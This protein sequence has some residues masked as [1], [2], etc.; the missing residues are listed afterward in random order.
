MVFVYRQIHKIEVQSKNLGLK[1]SLH[2]YARNR[3]YL[4]LDSV[5]VF[6]HTK[7]KYT[8]LGMD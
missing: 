2:F 3:L 4:D 6:E 5:L 7:R 8:E 1:K